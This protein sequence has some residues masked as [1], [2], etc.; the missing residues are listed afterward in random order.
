MECNRCLWKEE[1]GEAHFP[2]RIVSGSPNILLAG[3]PTRLLCPDCPYIC[4]VLVQFCSCSRTNHIPGAGQTER[5]CCLHFAERFRLISSVN[6]THADPCLGAVSQAPTG[7]KIQ[8]PNHQGTN[9]IFST[10]TGLFFFC[11][12]PAPFPVASSLLWIIWPLL[13]VHSW[14]HTVVKCFGLLMC[15][16]LLLV[17]MAAVML[18]TRE[19]VMARGAF[20]RSKKL[21]KFQFL[22][23]CPA[24]TGNSSK[25][26]VLPLEVHLWW[27]YSDDIMDRNFMYVPHVC[28]SAAHTAPLPPGPVK[29]YWML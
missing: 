28:S 14:L 15:K 5:H 26:R 17:F 19:H 3:K 18:R 12:M 27:L 1:R 21:I 22:R 7:S 16:C 23:R 6:K 9:I 2:R 24:L 13:K 29:N 11:M 25:T 4:M 8:P 10:Q 20:L